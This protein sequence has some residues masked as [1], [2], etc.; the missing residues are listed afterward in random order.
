M[1]TNDTIET[2]DRALKMIRALWKEGYKYKKAGVIVMDTVPELQI[3]SDMFDVV[4][5]SKARK[6][7]VAMD[8]VSKKYG[9][10]LLRLG[11][12]DQGNDW[13]LQSE[14]LS[15]RYTTDWDQLMVLSF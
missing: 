8:L 12:A 15:P 1:E 6:S 5:R 7:M 14:L 13:K 11:I 9:A 2:T 4:D 10:D 3:Q